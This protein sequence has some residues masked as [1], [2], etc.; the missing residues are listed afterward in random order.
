MARPKK[1]TTLIDLAEAEKVVSELIEKQDLRISVLEFMRLNFQKFKNTG[2]SRQTI[3]ERLTSGGLNLGTFNAFSQR[4]TRIEKSGISN[5]ANN[6]VSACVAEEVVEKQEP[7][8]SSDRERG[9][10]EVKTPEEPKKKTNLAL[11][12][13]YAPD[14][15]ELEITETGAK[16]FKITSAK[17]K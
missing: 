16:K 17:N 5:S 12:P 1:E 10:P 9:G 3:Y 2:L 6:P 4:W 11:P 15:T 8:R 14:G 7:D 13:I